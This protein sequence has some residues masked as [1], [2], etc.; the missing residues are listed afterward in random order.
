MSEINQR[1]TAPGINLSQPQLSDNATYVA[2]SRYALK[3]RNG[4]TKE[5]VKDIFWRVASN[6]AKGDVGFGASESEV[7]KLSTEFY[8]M[9]AKQEFFPGTPCLLNAGK[10]C[11]QMSACFV[12]PIEDSM[13]SIMK[14]NGGHGHDS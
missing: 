7:M 11:Q 12:L 14:N 4:Q 6:L 5:E 13:E 8:E 9:M 10:K 2:K 3:E 1:N